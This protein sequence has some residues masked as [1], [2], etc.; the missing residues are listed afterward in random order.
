M[1][2]RLKEV[3]GINEKYRISYGLQYDA[4]ELVIQ[5]PDWEEYRSEEEA[6]KNSENRMV[7]ALL[8][9][10]AIFLFYGSTLL[11]FLPDQTEFYRFSYIDEKVY[12]RLGPPLTHEDIDMLIEK[13]MLEE[14]I[15]S[16]RYILTDE[17]YIEFQGDLREVFTALQKIREPAYQLPQRFQ[18]KREVSGYLF[19]SIWYQ[20]ELVKEAEHGY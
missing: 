7:S 16:S 19:E 13:D 1:L 10:D 5:L 2:F 15:F 11:E 20:T 4:W 17:D 12:E 8:T 18:E 6:K 9:A 14:V 3:R